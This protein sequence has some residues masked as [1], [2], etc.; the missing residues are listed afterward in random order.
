MTERIALHVCPV[1]KEEHLDDTFKSHLDNHFN[2][3]PVGPEVGTSPNK[4]LVEGLCVD[5]LA[6]SYKSLSVTAS[7]TY[8]KLTREQ[9]FVAAMAITINHLQ[10]VASCLE[11]LQPAV[12]SPKHRII[13]RLSKIWVQELSENYNLCVNEPC[14]ANFSIAATHLISVIS[15]FHTILK[16]DT[17]TKKRK[18]INLSWTTTFDEQP[19][20]TD[21]LPS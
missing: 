15:D 21:E 12:L 8:R 11:P 3:I 13:Q 19:N 2:S 20:L 1:C 10:T 6:E 7:D 5:A 16:D 14:D 17:P 18:E 9:S 4:Q